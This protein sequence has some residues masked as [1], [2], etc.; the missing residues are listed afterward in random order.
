[1]L[2]DALDVFQAATEDVSPALV[3]PHVRKVVN[4]L[5]E[6]QLRGVAVALAV[7]AVWR[8]P[9]ALV[10][11]EHAGNIRLRVR[12]VRKWI[13]RLRLEASWIAS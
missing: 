4:A 3:I 5:D 7:E 10:E 2:L 1:M 12:Q 9:L 11:P 8:M 6:D 13:T